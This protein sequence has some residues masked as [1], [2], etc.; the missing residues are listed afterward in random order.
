[1]ATEDRRHG[2]VGVE[3]SSDPARIEVMAMLQELVGQSI[4][5]CIDLGRS[6]VRSIMSSESLEIDK[7]DHPPRCT[8]IQISWWRSHVSSHWLPS[9]RDRVVSSYHCAAIP[10]ECPMLCQDRPMPHR[11]WR[12]GQMRA[13]SSVLMW[14]IVSPFDHRLLAIADYFSR[15]ERRITMPLERQVSLCCSQT[16]IRVRRLSSSP[17]AYEGHAL[18]MGNDGGCR[19]SYSWINC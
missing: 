13:P 14:G 7:P 18:F 19:I 9:T 5:V 16:N 4:E 1:M 15:F 3:R 11:R 6:R 17:S 10:C 2:F 8:F 12:G